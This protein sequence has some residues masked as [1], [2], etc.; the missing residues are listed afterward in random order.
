[1]R[2][3]SLATPLALLAALGFAATPALA[4]GPGGHLEITEVVVDAAAETLTM[5]GRDFDFGGPLAVELGEIGDI[6]PLCAAS[7]A[8]PPQT[9]V[10]DFGATGLPPAGDY[11]LT[12]STGRGQSKTDEYDLTIAAAPPG[13]PPVLTFYRRSAT[14]TAAGGG[15]VEVITATALCDAGDVV[16]GGG[17]RHDIGAGPHSMIQDLTNAPNAGG[18]GWV[19][20][21]ERAMEAGS[22]LEVWAICADVAP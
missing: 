11:L 20:R 15:G 10:C 7:F 12:V 8:P 6:T 18:T 21:I 22:I 14:D 17:I 5:S 9:I 4:A 16:T 3:S 2:R 13:P 1:M 19:G